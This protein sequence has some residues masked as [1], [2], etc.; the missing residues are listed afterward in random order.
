MAVA[1]IELAAR[2][3]QLQYVAA[4]KVTLQMTKQ[5][6]GMCNFCVWQLYETG[7]GGY[8]LMYYGN[9]TV[10]NFCCAG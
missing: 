6:L 2:N 5:T 4:V 8:V 1:F 10:F 3:Q 9:I 7:K